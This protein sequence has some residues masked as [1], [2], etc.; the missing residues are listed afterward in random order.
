MGA[1]VVRLIMWAPLTALE[2]PTLGDKSPQEQKQRE[3]KE[4]GF[5]DRESPDESEKRQNKMDDTQRTHRGKGTD[6]SEL[7]RIK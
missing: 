6:E 7:E 4:R 1:V 3:M 5:R 2:E